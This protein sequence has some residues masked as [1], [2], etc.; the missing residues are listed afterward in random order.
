MINQP[1]FA[2]C[3]TEDYRRLDRILDRDNDVA[4]GFFAPLQLQNPAITEEQRRN[5]LA[6][7]EAEDIS[8]DDI[9]RIA[10]SARIVGQIQA[11]PVATR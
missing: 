4:A 1:V 3:H 10:N 2:F 6:Y 7:I 9:Q 11:T 8:E 5:I